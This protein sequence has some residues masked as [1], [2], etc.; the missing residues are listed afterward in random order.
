M[1]RIELAGTHENGGPR[2][3]PGHAARLPD[4]AAVTAPGRLA[5][6]PT[7][8]DTVLASGTGCVDIISGQAA[9]RPPVRLS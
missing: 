8:S 9:K 6:W 5:A 7:A 2:G 4:G 3:S 1:T